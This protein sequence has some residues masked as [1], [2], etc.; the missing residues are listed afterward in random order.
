M[1]NLPA[2]KHVALVSQAHG[3][4]FRCYLDIMEG[5]QRLAKLIIS[6]DDQSNGNIPSDLEKL[7]T[8]ILSTISEFKHFRKMKENPSS[9]TNLDNEKAPSS[10]THNSDKEVEKM[11]SLDVHEVYKIF[12][13][14]FPQKELRADEF[15]NILSQVFDLN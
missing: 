9:I 1:K 7:A 4:L 15:L 11:T 12:L 10:V 14:I 5:L 2:A 8:E 6:A 3:F 13:G